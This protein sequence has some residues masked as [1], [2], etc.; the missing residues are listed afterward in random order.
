VSRFAAVVLLCLAVT[1]ARGSAQVA[2]ETCF[3]A[4]A[5][6]VGTEGK[7]AIIG[8][9]GP[10]VI[11]TL[12]GDD[13]V[14][15]GAG[16]DRVCTGAGNDAV[17]GEQGDDSIDEGAGSGDA[18]YY[19]GSPGPVQVNLT[20]GTATGAA[21]RDS[22]S[23]IESV[24]GSDFNDT[25]VG[26]AEINV[27][28]GE[29][30]ND[31]IDGGSSSDGLLGGFG[32]D[33]LVGRLGDGDAA[34]YYDAQRGG[35]QAD[36]QTGIGGSAELGRDTMTNVESLIGSIFADRLS[37]DQ[38]LNFLLGSDGNDT[39][40]GRAG[41]DVAFFAF[42]PVSASLA[43]RRS[44]GEGTDTLA[45]F[46][47]LAGSPGNDNLIG[48]AKQNFLQGGAGDDSISGGAGPDIV[49]GK[50][51]SDRLSGG[52]GDDKLFGGSGNDALN[53]DAGMA[54]SVSYI[55][56]PAG[57]RA[58]LAAGTATG[59][60]GSDR[61]S[62]VEGLSGSI[63]PDNLAGDAKAN[64]IFG[65]DGNDTISTGAGSDFAGGGAGADTI[66][67]GAGN[68][69]CL[70]EQHGQ[71]CEISGAP[72]IPGAPDAPPVQ[73]PTAPGPVLSSRPSLQLLAWMARAA[74]R[75][76]SSPLA[77]MPPLPPRQTARFPSAVRTT[78]GYEYS[79]EPVCIASKRGG[80]TEIAP[81]QVV[82]PVGDDGGRE[83]AWWQATLFRQ[84]SNGRFTKRQLKTTWARAQLAGDVVIPG[85]V[86]WKDV[87]GRRAF[88]SPVAVRV[89][90][91]RYVW[92]G[93]IYWVRSG[94]RIFAP[95]EPHLI[96]A[97]TIRHDKN[98]TFR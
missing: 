45:G 42:E 3:G 50:E 37:G 14:V 29:A 34:I 7:D 28:A 92:K 58:D 86:V 61:L 47:G 91:G 22:L 96:R 16:N 36:L 26:N 1:A 65:S 64:E 23:G 84:G 32:D 72:A 74:K 40:D 11:V 59:G 4:A 56:S 39:L 83:E 80:V 62:G 95:I 8:T 30:G 98:C 18:V 5:T 25:L 43:S 20:T 79:A 97:Q 17:L 68:D 41:F 2:A 67:A 27:L 66:Q 15:A 49:L 93:Q 90:R 54:D 75:M 70:D 9:A 21:G 81:P 31:R 6:I 87:G 78:A 88:R 48:D 12:G 94:G 57:V 10:D 53:G 69:Y 33:T 52:T 51:G 46:E 24:T 35:V 63:F 89:P 82:R 73:S 71:G 38:G 76:T 55:D 19:F 13:S 77:T 85:V 44:Q 60:E